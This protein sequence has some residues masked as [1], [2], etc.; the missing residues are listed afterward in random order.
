[1]Q[2]FSFH[3]FQAKR[4]GPKN[5]YYPASSRNNDEIVM[6]D[7]SIGRGGTVHPFFKGASMDSILTSNANDQDLSE[8][9]SALEKLNSQSEETIQFLLRKLTV[10]ETKLQ[11]QVESFEAE[12]SEWKEKHAAVDEAIQRVGAAAVETTN[13]PPQC[14]ANDTNDAHDRLRRRNDEIV[15][16]IGR[17]TYENGQLLSSCRRHEEEGIE[18]DDLRVFADELDGENEELRERMD[19]MCFKLD[20]FTKV[21]EECVRRYETKLTELK[22]E[23]NRA[24]TSMEESNAKLSKKLRSKTADVDKL[25]TENDAV[26][27][28]CEALHNKIITLRKALDES[29]GSDGGGSVVIDETSNERD[30]KLATLERERVAWSN[31]N[32]S[33]RILFAGYD[34]ND[35]KEER[36]SISMMT[37]D[38][39]WL[40]LR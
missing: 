28:T 29:S 15:E 2:Y 9:A 25:M 8:L 10:V 3:K 22:N 39:S 21:H 18:R 38:V 11:R 17:L 36:D 4:A 32:R 13:D 27:E 33:S 34:E 1:L 23:K 37:D 7:G 24:I 35:D 26:Y 16:K 19:N 20:D 31:G 30:T 5:N 14:E 12:I 40:H 6:T